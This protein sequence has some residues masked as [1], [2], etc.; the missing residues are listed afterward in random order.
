LTLRLEDGAANWVIPQLPPEQATW[1]DHARRAYLGEVA[2]NW[3]GK[4][5]ELASLIDHLK[6]SIEPLLTF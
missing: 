5:K 4:E 3:E 2:D 1:L 6:K